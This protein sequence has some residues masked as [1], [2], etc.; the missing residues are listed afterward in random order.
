MRW[1][2]VSDGAAVSVGRWFA[3]GV[4]VALVLWISSS[5]FTSLGVGSQAAFNR[6]RLTLWPTSIL[7]LADPANRSLLVPLIAGLANGVVYAAARW[8]WLFGRGDHRARWLPMGTLLSLWTFYVVYM[9][10]VS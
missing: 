9:Y 4:S 3:I 1:S 6:M 8:C 7:L 10:Q 2:T 5:A